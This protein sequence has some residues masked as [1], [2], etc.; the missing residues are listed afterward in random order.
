MSILSA[1]GIS[2]SGFGGLLPPG[3]NCP[4]R[5]ATMFQ[6]GRQHTI[7]PWNATPMRGMSHSKAAYTSVD[8]FTNA[9]LHTVYEHSLS[10]SFQIGRLSLLFSAAGSDPH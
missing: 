3:G 7:Y 9:F 1:F 6:F 4:G 10:A 2:Q 8:R 5:N